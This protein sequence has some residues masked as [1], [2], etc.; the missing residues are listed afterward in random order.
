MT[1]DLFSLSG[2]F[3]LGEP[4]KHSGHAF[5]TARL[6]MFCPLLTLQLFQS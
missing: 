2:L 3:Q 5:F 1:S 6:S 4:F